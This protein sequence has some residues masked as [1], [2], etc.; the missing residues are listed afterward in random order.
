LINSEAE[1]GR[2]S[3]GSCMRIGC[4][5]SHRRARS[6]PMRKSLQWGSLHQIKWG[7]RGQLIRV[8]MGASSL[9]GVADLSRTADRSVPSLTPSGRKRREWDPDCQPGS[10]SFFPKSLQHCPLSKEA[11][12]LSNGRTYCQARSRKSIRDST[13]DEHVASRP[14]ATR[15]ACSRTIA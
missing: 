8:W 15:A 6:R 4:C 2:V 12:L 9:T 14:R 13:P 10:F 3:P 1:A 11:E 7:K 5:S